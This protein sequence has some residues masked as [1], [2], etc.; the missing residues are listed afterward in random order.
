MMKR[1][2]NNDDQ[3]DNNDD[4]STLRKE[5]SRPYAAKLSVMRNF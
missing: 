5:K 3:E 4:L 1:E 2:D